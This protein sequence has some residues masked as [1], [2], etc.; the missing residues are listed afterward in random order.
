MKLDP[1][2]ARAI[3]RALRLG[4]F[5]LLLAGCTDV[6]PVVKVGILAPFEGLYRRTGYAALDAARAAIA[7]APGDPV[8][9]IPLAL[10]DSADPRRAA[11][12]LRVDPPVRAIVGPLAPAQA[13]IAGIARRDPAITWIAPYAVDP[14][15]GFA[16]PAVSDA[17]ATGLVAAA[18]DA[19][20]RQGAQLLVLAGDDTGW[21]ALAVEEWSTVAGMPVTRLA[22]SASDIT[23]LA[24]DEA[25]FWLGAPDTAADF[26]N[27]LR[28]VYPDMPVW[29]AL[30]GSDPVL[31][32]RANIDRKLYW[33][34]WS[35]S[36]YNGWAA[37]RTSSTPDAFL[38]YQATLA[39]IDAVRGD[40]ATSTV[41]WHVEL[42]EYG[43]DGVSRPFI[44]G[45]ANALE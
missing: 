3:G 5:L 10:D 33:L 40:A 34:A 42:F 45:Q 24:G 31:T 38:V 23:A 19:A 8:A 44:P 4:I 26:I 16:D 7:G 15:G 12:K 6:R 17:W 36:H 11:Q 28:P 18:G 13:A 32:E 14:A 9:L 22:G 35:N 41:P 2:P 21:P 43:P 39:A 29:I 25:I 30:G 20:R 27:R 1:W 37:Q